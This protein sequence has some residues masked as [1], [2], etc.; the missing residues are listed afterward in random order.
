MTNI[1]TDKQIEYY[2]ENGFLFSCR[3]LAESDAIAY[4]AELEDY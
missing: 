3:L 1:L 2:K 4:F